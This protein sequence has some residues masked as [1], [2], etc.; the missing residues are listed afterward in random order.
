MFSIGDRLTA[1]ILHTGD[2]QHGLFSIH[3]LFLPPPSFLPS[4]LSAL[5]I[6]HSVVNT[7][8]PYI[9][10]SREIPI[11]AWGVPDHNHHHSAV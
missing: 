6:P 2:D 7:P 8:K 5:A 1:I 4:Y 10:V 9:W 3:L 11:F